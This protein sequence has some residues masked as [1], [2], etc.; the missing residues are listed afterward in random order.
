MPPQLTTKAIHRGHMIW[1][2]EFFLFLGLATMPI[3][4][5]SS[6][7]L[8]YEDDGTSRE[9][10]THLESS[11]SQVGEIDFKRVSAEELNKDEWSEKCDLLVIP[12]GR[13]LEYVRKI[14]VNTLDSIRKFIREGGSYLGIC[15][16]AYFSSS[17]V[18]FEPDSRFAVYGNREL[19]LFG[20]TAYG[21]AYS[22]FTF[23]PSDQRVTKVQ[24]KEYPPEPDKVGHFYHMGGCYFE[25]EEVEKLGWTIVAEYVHRKSVAIIENTLGKGRIILSCPHIEFDPAVSLDDY[26]TSQSWHKELLKYSNET[27]Q[28]FQHLINRLLLKPTTKN[29]SSSCNQA[30]APAL[31]EKDKEKSKDLL[32]S[33]EEA[34]L[35]KT[36]EKGNDGSL[37]P[38]PSTIEAIESTDKVQTLNS[39]DPESSRSSDSTEA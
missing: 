7:I 3:L 6:K 15:G 39:T 36:E 12:G 37:P 19:K 21:A 34:D 10:I 11:L 1:I 8:I 26:Y 24:M 22:P 23:S 27:R 28:I 14:S 13:D 38:L 5:S 29:D 25:Q 18:N 33:G 30:A 32:S 35:S 20:G 16:G 2:G 9:L 4:V 17:K 31:D